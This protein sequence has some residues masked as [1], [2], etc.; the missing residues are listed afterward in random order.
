[1]LI[2]SKGI[3][4]LI[5]QYL[6]NLPTGTPITIIFGYDTKHSDKHAIDYLTHYDRIDNPSHNS[7]FGHTQETINPTNGVS[8]VSGSANDTFPI[9]APSSAGSP[10]T[11]Q[12][13]SSFNVLPDDE[14]VMSIWNGDITSMAYVFQE[15]LTA[16]QSETQISVT[17]TASSS[18]VVLAWGGHI[19]TREDW[20]YNA[21]GI[22]MSAGGISGSPYHM[23]LINWSLNNLGNQDRSLSAVAVYTPPGSI[24]II[25]DTTLDA[26]QD[27]S[28]NTTGSGLSSFSLD[29]DS[30]S[31]LTNTKTFT[32][33]T[34]G[35][36]SV[37]EGAQIDYD[38]TGLV[39]TDPTNNSNIDLATRTAAINLAAGESVTCTFTNTLQKGTVELKKV[40][41]GTAGQTTLNIGTSAAGSEIDHQQTGSNGTPPLTTG[42]NEVDTGTYYMS[43]SGGLDNY[44]KSALSCY[45]D[46]ND[47]GTNDGEPSV[48]VGTNDSVAVGA[49]EH[50][51]CTYTNTRQTGT[52]IVKKVMVGGTDT[53]NYTGTPNGSISVNNETIHTTVDTGQYTST[54]GI[55]AGWS[56]TDITCDDSNSTDNVSTRTATFNVD[57]GETVTCTFTNGKL[58]TLTLSKT[59][60]TD[61]GG[62]AVADDFQAYIN[63]IEVDWENTQTLTPGIY[64][65]SEDNLTG[66]SAS[67]WGTNCTAGGTVTL[68]YGDNKTCTIT[69]NDQAPHL[70]VIKHVINDNGG[71]KDAEDFTTTIS[72][73]TTANPTAAGVESPGVNNVL[74][75]VGSYSVDEGD[76][77]G[78]NKTL[79]T[80][81]TGTIALGDNKTCTITND[82]IAPKLHLRKVVI[83]DNGGTATVNDFTLTAN[84]TESNDISGTSPVDSGE[85]LQAD[86]F[87]LS[88]TSPAGYSASD[89]V[90]VGGTQDGSNITLGINEEATCTITN[91]DIQPKLT[92]I[93]VVENNYGGTLGVSNFPLF[94]GTTEVVSEESNG[95]NS[96]TYI[97]SETEQYGYSASDW[98]GDCTA[99]GEVILSV[100]DDKTCTITNSDIQPKLT[101]TKIVI[102]DNGGNKQVSDFP[103]FVDAI[104]V[105][106]GVQ[107]GFD[108]GNYTA[109]ET[110][111]TGYAASDWSGDCNTDGS[112]TLNVGDVK[113]CTITNDDIAPKLTLVKT[114]V[115]DN[116]GEAVVSDFPLFINGAPA[117]S[118]TSYEQSANVELTATET[119]R[120]GYAPSVWGGDCATDGTITLLPG[121]DKT[122]TIT[123]DDIQPKLKLIK[124]VTNNNG[125]T[126]EVSDFPL[127]VDST[128]VTSGVQNGFDAGTYT[129]SE[130]QQSG[131]TASIW[132]GDCSSDGLVTLEVGDIKTCE[133]TNDD[134]SP[135]LTIVKIADP[136]DCQDFTFTGNSGLGSFILDDNQD[137]VGCT[138]TDQPQSKPFNNILANNSYTITEA[139][140]NSYWEF[141]GVS[142]TVTGTE[143]PYTFTPV[144]NGLTINLNLADDVTCTF[145]NHKTSPT[146]T[147]GFWQTHTI[148]TSG[149]FAANFADG[150]LIGTVLSGHKGLI[151]NAAGVGQSELFGAFFA[152]ISKT[153]T[154]A[155]RSQLDQARIQLLQQLVAAKLNCAAFGCQSSVQTLIINADIAYAGNNKNLIQN[156][157]GLLDDYNKSGDTIII[158]NAGSATPQ[159]SK[160]YA[161]L[162]F[163]NNP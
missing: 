72:G 21:T 27:F 135:K 30:D 62:T 56:L 116:G 46:E 90:C 1:M 43:E 117:T 114:V 139:I 126:L 129:A 163:W 102:N 153:T 65:A 4:F 71:T 86:T 136:K 7:V 132:S 118:G 97:A 144:T 16:S 73:V 125:G 8:G 108:A 121:D 36:Y 156:Y 61:N 100:G 67:D 137:V 94:V 24:T 85:T 88:E 103:L 127:L 124:H 12:P 146:R 20:G 80:D 157:T 19:A 2:L 111:F 133:I 148:Y 77:S 154:G 93:K 28:F 142:C 63:D 53:F 5:D 26:A 96:G 106:S 47:N 104:G 122:C 87:A 64:T 15:D 107:N 68:A 60:I 11:G 89:W 123:N 152:P 147:L 145:I 120:T 83:T 161:N 6:T 54:E 9:P 99:E 81:C 18:T 92:L 150:M 110:P 66:Y 57:S 155:K 74:T 17:F 159:L 51:I 59:V 38:L 78:Y 141:K 112:V 151:F 55:K 143:T 58:P 52:I 44:S 29:D 115:N 22:P 119:P 162:A 25:K 13:T 23:R 75:S 35:S 113:S 101:L 158:G 31:T 69:N 91:D 70:I 149:I 48:T 10:V 37:T 34:A 49:G 134:I 14:R 82:D 32:G 3:Q 130:T 40:W 109:S 76:H 98:S 138:D 160:S 41:S 131:Y 39:C 105:T 140:P 45:N 84:G 79:S 42:Q 50:V 33:L 95:F 128:G